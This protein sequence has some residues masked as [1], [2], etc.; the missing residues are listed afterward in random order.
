MVVKIKS[1][2]VSFVQDWSCEDW[3]K[4]IG[5]VKEKN[6]NLGWLPIFWVEIKIGNT[7]V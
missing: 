1:L 7:L 5:V 2:D 6:I 3:T 4:F